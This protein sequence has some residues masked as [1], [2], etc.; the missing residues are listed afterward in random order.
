MSATFVKDFVVSMVIK[1]ILMSSYLFPI[2]FKIGGSSRDWSTKMTS[3]SII[4]FNS[5][6]F[7][8]L[9]SSL[10]DWQ[11][12]TLR[13]LIAVFVSSSFSLFAIY[14]VVYSFVLLIKGAKETISLAQTK[15]AVP[16]PNCML[17]SLWG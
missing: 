13:I 6:T 8:S 1:C 7:L 12:H 2:C 11:A 15:D 17:K 14:L 10:L 5:L 16:G 4:L 9:H 3:L